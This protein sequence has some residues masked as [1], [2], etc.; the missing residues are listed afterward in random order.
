MNTEMENKE[1]TPRE[2]GEI[3]VKTLDAK[4]AK[5]IKLLRIDDKTVLADYFVICEG[6]S[7][8]QIKA[9]A[10]EVEYKMGLYGKP[11]LRMEGY[12]EGVWVILDFASVIVHIFSRDAREFYKLEKLWDNGTEIKLELEEN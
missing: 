9:L 8:T 7:N 2:L 1:L 10:G 12:S 3:I 6:T 4:K 5:D 11:V